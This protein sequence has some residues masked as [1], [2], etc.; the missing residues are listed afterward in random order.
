MEALT[1]SIDKVGDDMTLAKIDKG[2]QIMY[3]AVLTPGAKWLDKMELKLK[4]QPDTQTPAEVV[5]NARCYSTGLFPMTIPG[6]V[7]LNLLLFF[8]PF[9]DWGKCANSLKRVKTLLSQTMNEQIAVKT[10]YSSPLQAGK[11]Q[12]VSRSL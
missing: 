12:E 4:S 10:L 3:V 6:A 5:I 8:V 9:F 7:V 2:K 1:T 11:K